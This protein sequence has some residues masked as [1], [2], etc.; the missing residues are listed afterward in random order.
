MGRIGDVVDK[1]EEPVGKE[2][3]IKGD[4]LLILDYKLLNDSYVLEDGREVGS[5]FVI[6]YFKDTTDGDQ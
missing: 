3:V 1:A 4:T 5:R 6:E 2:I